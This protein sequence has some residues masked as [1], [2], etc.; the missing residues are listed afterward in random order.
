MSDV[1]FDTIEGASYELVG[2]SKRL[3]RTGC[4]WN[5][6]ANAVSDPL[7][8][9]AGMEAIGIFPGDKMP[10]DSDLILSK[11]RFVP[12]TT[13]GLR[14]ELTYETNSFSPT[15]YIITRDNRTE[16]RSTNLVPGTRMP[17][18][19][20]AFKFNNGTGPVKIK[21][22]IVTHV[23][24]ISYKVLN[25]FMVKF[26]SLESNSGAV[27]A[28]TVGD[29]C[30][31]DGLWQG[32]PT[33]YW[34]LTRYLTQESR[35]SGSYS[36]NASAESRVVEDWSETFL[37]RDQHTGEWASPG[38]DVFGVVNAFSYVYGQIYSATGNGV[39]R[40][41]PFPTANFRSIFGF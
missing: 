16:H 15:A 10:G 12:F 11:M 13:N 7:V 6:P 31:N 2:Q 39:A 22:D 35:Y 32:L 26:G 9:F 5:L 33:G 37:L 14:F 38:D 8:L 34:R 1:I 4:V 23:I 29:N 40:Y 27:A 3:V 30:V 28:N 41:G 24:P 20:P 36:I 17:F 21:E 19:V 25:V 18:R